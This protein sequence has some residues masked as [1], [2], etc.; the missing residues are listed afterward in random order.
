MNIQFPSFIGRDRELSKIARQIERRGE[1]VVVNIA[2]PGGIGKTA[3]LRSIK[4]KYQSTSSVLVTEIIDFS[5]TVHRSEAWILEQIIAVA[6][7]KFPLH[8]KKMHKL[9]SAS[10]PFT[11][12]QYENELVDAF[13]E[14]FNKIASQH[15]FVLLFDTLEL[16][17]DSPL[18]VFILELTKRLN[19]AVLVLAGRRNDQEEFAAELDRIFKK[20]KVKNIKLEG[21]GEKEAIQ[22][23]EQ[24]ITPHLSS[25][26]PD[27]QKNIYFLSEGKPIKI[28]LSLDW[29]DRGIPIMPEIIKM[30]PSALRKMKAEEISFLRSQFEFALM[31]GIRKFQSPVDE[32]I[33][34][35]A[36]FSKRFNRKMLEFFFLSDLEPR[37][38]ARKSK[39][40][41]AEI[42]E[43]PFVKYTNDDYFVL[44][45]E[46]ARL[47]QSYVWD[48]AEDPDRTLRKELSEKICDY[49]E[50]ELKTL[51]KW[52]KSTEQQRV[53]RRSYEVEALY[54]RLYADF[55]SGFWHFERL[56][57]ML[58]EDRR[59]GLATLALNFV[60][61]FKT[62]PAFTKVMQCFINGYYSGGVLIAQQ[63]FEIASK[64]LVEG[65]RQLEELFASYEWEKASPL[66]HYLR[67]RSYLVYQQLGYCHRSMGDWK[68]AE[69][70]YQRS[71]KLAL[72]VADKVFQLPKAFDRKKALVEQIA[73]ILNN[74]ANL[75]RLTG[76]FR[77]ARLLCQT[78][79]LLR[80]NWGL[81]TVMSLYVMS[82]ILWEMGDTAESVVYLNKAERECTDDYKLALLKKYHAYVLFRTGLT[83]QALPILD[84]AE[85]IFRQKV[86]RS[87]LADALNIRC[88]IYRTDVGLIAEKVHRRSYMK[89]IEE[90]G[91]EA[92]I[93]ANQ[94]NDKFR[95]AECHLTQAFHYY[96]WSKTDSKKEILYRQLA[97]D[98]W[99]MGVELAKGG[100]HQIYSLYCQLRGDLS[101][102]AHKPDYEFAFEQYT[103][104][105]KI[106][107]HFKEASYER[108]IDHLGER[109]R[110]LSNT[111]SERALYFINKIIVAW[112]KD[113]EVNQR[114]DLVEELLEVKRTIEENK[115]LKEL[116]HKYDLAMLEGKLVEASQYSD[117]I[118]TIPGFYTDANRAEILLDKSQV[119]YRQEHFAEARRYAKVALQLGHNLNADRLIGNAHLIL[120]AI[121]W[122]TTSTAEAADHLKIAIQIFNKI[123]DKI[124]LARAQRFQN[125]I[126]YRTGN[127]DQLID[128]MREVVEVFEKN[129]MNAEAADLQNLMSRVARTDTVN[130]NYKM[131][132]KFAN[133]A[134]AKAEISKD[135]YR[136]AECLL[137]LAAL[138]QREKKYE[139]VLSYYKKGIA[140][141]PAE[142]H[143]IRSVYEGVLGAAYYEM[144]RQASGK[145]MDEY[146]S[147]AVDAFIKELVEA[148]QSKPASLVRAIK[149]IFDFLVNLPSEE[150]V[151]K[152]TQHI[153]QSVKILQTKY[154]QLERSTPSI[155]QMLAQVRQVY[156][157]LQT[158]LVIKEP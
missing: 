74:L 152:C 71:L 21:F 52:A 8:K 141:L 24:T 38:K 151:I 104:Q 50:Q 116:K 58:T 91:R 19:N 143:A 7:K 65:E 47:V 54:Y 153:D 148:S 144:A 75:Y 110:S 60:Q 61:E 124:G 40:L 101:F 46:M 127:F 55:R 108:G 17:Q 33:L 109:L 118:L 102:D 115:K 98:Q 35:M 2:G 78:G 18:F 26:H 107:T 111:E 155:E 114:T 84:E 135:A 154:A 133:E 105:C 136:K 5:H 67:E 79:I 86:L 157:F 34:Y 73:E 139:D 87:E 88:R 146:L 31:E 119:A 120:T 63:K 147:Y 112:G 42:K 103:E 3:I 80:Q 128:R 132:R 32:I 131:A 28:A 76:E 90:L 15:R 100:Y 126:L 1:V 68:Y 106:G 9:Q 85:T 27:L 156:P 82:M 95:I 48:T 53:V 134:F 44:H 51:P 117:E 93:L 99:N 69:E 150:Q 56:F 140:L 142:A 57:E 149:L 12:L 39:K 72:E 92:Y 81:E 16:V 96:Q 125:Y 41:L 23:F 25:V 30:E 94:S 4:E 64:K 11:R 59:S 10:E 29:L 137:S 138:S 113:P 145:K 83:E 20:D 62:E 129:H 43:L 130:S 70:N 22:Y 49:Y 6:S 66:D 158:D 37:E 123:D 45:D 121:L 122:D 97:L 13:V 89:Y 14:D 36:H 77:E